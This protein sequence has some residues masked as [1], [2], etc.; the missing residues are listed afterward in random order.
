MTNILNLTKIEISKL[1]DYFHY[2]I[3]TSKKIMKIVD[4]TENKE[5]LIAQVQKREHQL[6]YN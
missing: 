1:Y 5:E 6:Y 2:N 4:G 3:S